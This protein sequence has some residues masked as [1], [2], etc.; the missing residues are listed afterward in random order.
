MFD[1]IACHKSHASVLL[2]YGINVESSVTRKMAVDG[3]YLF[4]ILIHE[5]LYH[6]IVPRDDIDHEYHY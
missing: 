6:L 1:I 4:S 3:N 2:T 5:K